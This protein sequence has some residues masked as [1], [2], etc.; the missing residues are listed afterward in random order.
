MSGY[1]SSD[2]NPTYSQSLSFSPEEGE[3]D[4]AYQQRIYGDFYREPVELVTRGVTLPGPTL[5]ADPAE[6]FQFTPGDFYREEDNVFKGVSL[7]PGFGEL[8]EE[9]LFQQ[10]LASPVLNALDKSSVGLSSVDRFNEEHHPPAAPD[11]NFFQYEVT[12]LQ[13]S[14]AEPFTIGNELLNFFSS[15]VVS[16]LLKVNRVKFSIKAEVFMNGAMCTLKTRTYSQRDDTYAIE[17]QRRSGDSITFNYAFQ[18]AVNF[19]KSSFVTVPGHKELVDEALDLLPPPLQRHGSP[20]SSDGEISPLLDMAGLHEHPGLQA[21]SANALA[22]MAQDG[23]AVMSLCTEAAFQE[24]QKL[25]QSDNTDVAYPTACL[26]GRLA[27]CPEASE[28][29]ANQSLLLIILHKIDSKSTRELIQKELAQALA[30]AIRH[31]APKMG[32][33][34]RLLQALQASIKDWAS[35]DQDICRNLEEAAHSLRFQLA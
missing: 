7:Q 18:Q 14:T 34:T 5:V 28:F 31:C 6:G 8:P 21:E 15:K 26:L 30:S 11:S 35:Y 32:D 3:E 4:C 1:G 16:S 23:T 9:L 22:E 13:V 33:H 20:T 19:L 24:F 29:F 2:L 25:L 10:D 27:L 17:F 12:T